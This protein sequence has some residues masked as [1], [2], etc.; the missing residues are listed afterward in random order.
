MNFSDILQ[1]NKLIIFLGGV[2]AV[3]LVGN[4]FVY[5][6]DGNQ[7][8]ESEQKNIKNN[9]REVLREDDIKKRE[10]ELIQEKKGVLKSPTVN[11]IT[12]IDTSSHES[13]FMYPGSTVLSQSNGVIVAQSVDTPS[14]ITDWYKEK[15]SGHDMNTTSVVTTNTNGAILN[16]VA[17]S[18]GEMTVEVEVSRSDSDN[19]TKMTVKIL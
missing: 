10:E 4:I 9:N 7:E 18:N 14:Q 13:V 3:L 19:F 16:K 8:I 2:L 6:T 5:I 17:A 12:P 1:K 11:P 15:V